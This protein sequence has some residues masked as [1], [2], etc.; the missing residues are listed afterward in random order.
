MERLVIIVTDSDN[1]HSDTQTLFSHVRNTARCVTDTIRSEATLDH[2]SYGRSECN[3]SH[4]P[5]AFHQCHQPASPAAES[6]CS[7]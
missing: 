7:K 1:E 4:R 5:S 3:S 6:A 2:R